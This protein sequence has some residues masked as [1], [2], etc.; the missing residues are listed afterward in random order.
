[1]KKKDGFI[2]ITVMLTMTIMYL[3]VFHLMFNTYLQERI[4][5]STAN[6]IQSFYLS[7]EKNLLMIH[8]EDYYNKILY[9]I[10]FDAFIN[11]KFTKRTIKIDIKDLKQNDSKEN[12]NIRFT[13]KNNRKELVLE[14]ESDY[15]SLLTKMNS[16]GTI[17]NQL[18]ELREP[19]LSDDIINSKY[20]DD[21][22]ILTKSIAE[23]ITVD[24][25]NMPNA[26]YSEK[27]SGFNRICLQ[28]KDSTN[29]EIA[30]YRDA[31]DIPYK[32]GSNKQYSMIIFKNANNE[33]LD[34]II[35]NPDK[36]DETLKLSGIL[37]VEGNIKITSGFEFNGIIVIKDG[38]I[39]VESVKKPKVLGLVIAHNSGNIMDAMEDLDI[40]YEPSHVYR[41]GILLPGFLQPEINLH[42]SN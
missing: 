24:H 31:M 16:S 27:F 28:R 5:I 21:L 41:H 30:C 9:P 26:Y 12:I 6:N 22:L 23:N 8:D 19:V 13:N 18:F 20:S 1:M 15:N 10:L 35:G 36:P 7:E 29:F 2:T 33:P 39:L 11:N 42:K 3:I 38:D 25:T 4:L 40:K 37:Y 32:A 17:V 14:S 34:L